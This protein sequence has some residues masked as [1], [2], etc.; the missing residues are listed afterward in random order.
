[1]RRI[2]CLLALFIAVS[3][4]GQLI[5]DKRVLDDIVATEAA[6]HHGVLK[7]RS[8]TPSR[9]YDLRY[10]RLELTID[11]AFRAING[12]VTHY[13]TA[14]TDLDRVVLDLNDSLVVTGVSH[15]G[16]GIPFTHEGHALT[17]DLPSALS[18]GTLD[19]LTVIYGGEPGTSGFDSFVQATHNGSPIVWTLS[20]PYG[21]LDWWPCKQDLNDKTDSLDVLLTV[22]A[23][24]RVASNG[25]LVA[26]TDLGDGTE[27]HHWRHRHPI[28]YYLVAFAVT[29]Y[30]TFTLHA[31]LED[32]TVEV[33]N[34]VFPENW[35]DAQA[36][37]PDVITQMQLFSQLFGEYPFADEQY[38]HAQFG[39]GGGMEHQTMSFMG[40]FHYE[41]IAHELAHQWFGDMVT[42]ASW[43]D[44][45]LNEGFATYLSGL[46]YEHLAPRY[47]L[48]F[49]RS[50][51]DLITT[52][53]DGSVRVTDTLSV[54]RLFSNRLT[55]AKGAYLVHM[56]RWVCGDEAFY[57]GIRNYLT[58]PGIR[59]A[60]AYTH[61]LVSHLEQAAGMDL[62]SFMQNWYVG[63]GFPTYTLN[64]A[65]DGAGP[66]NIQ[67]D[68]TTSHASVSFYA[69]PVPVRLKNA[70]QDTTIVLD[71]TFSGQ[72]FNVAIPFQA[73]SLLLD[74]DM[75]ILSGQNMVTHVPVSA[76]ATDRLLL[77]PSP[78]ETEAFVHLGSTINGTVAVE[79]VDATGRVVQHTVHTANDQRIVF[80]VRRL[81]PGHYTARLRYGGRT[82]SQRFLK[83]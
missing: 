81:M 12:Q 14:L 74:P 43:E 11:P 17:I 16:V 52:Q 47:W 49:K 39:W 41:L 58:D 66:V 42:C 27:R 1:M 35:D 79:I 15:Q 70:F 30:A 77:Y 65:Q 50:W 56:L 54:S 68:Q 45:W 23:G 63:Q 38:G 61:Q 26:A 28:N 9:G 13:F 64:W 25:V 19:S 59:H 48:P 18:E 5:I 60:S 62:S 31:P 10:H 57:Q 82:T 73:D 29:N 20:E 75:W 36:G 6:G 34:F 8:G 21:A 78:V 67:L 55:Y 72:L 22:P 83:M 33:H 40:N 24:Q 37:A 46:C 53:P 76:F 4:H 71:H 80:D 69:M 3:S 44:L 7:D 2:A 32:R 51:R